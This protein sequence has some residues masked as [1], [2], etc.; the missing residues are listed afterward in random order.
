MDITDFMEL[1]QDF[2]DKQCVQ[3]LVVIDNY[4][5]VLKET[6]NSNHGAL[7][8]EIERCVNAWVSNAN[9]VSRRYEREKF[10]VFFHNKEY[11]DII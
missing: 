9:G 11:N 5:E 4:D 8:G 2:D 10:L 6:P 1:K 7:L 3:C